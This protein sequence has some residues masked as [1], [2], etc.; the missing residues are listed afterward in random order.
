MSA[1]F[2]IGDRVKCLATHWDVSSDEDSDDEGDKFSEK[3]FAETGSLYRFGTVKLRLGPFTKKMYS[4]MWD[5]D[6]KREKSHRDHL[7]L[8]QEEEKDQ[9]EEEEEEEEPVSEE[10]RDAEDTSEEDDSDGK[11]SGGEDDDRDGVMEGEEVQC[12]NGTKWGV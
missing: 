9:D 8:L 2:A 6:S 7:I 3:H 5:G 4:I 11:E 12:N 1:F 10:D